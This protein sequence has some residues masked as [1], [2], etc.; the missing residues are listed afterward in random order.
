[1]NF[2]HSLFV[3]TL[4]LSCNAPSSQ[5]GFQS[6]W[7]NMPDQN[8]PGPDFWANRLQ[9]WYVANGRLECKR[10]ETGRPMRTLHWLTG[11]MEY[12]DGEMEMSVLTGKV[13]SAEGGENPQAASG[14]LLGSG[15]SM[16]Y[17]AAAW[18][19]NS[20]GKEG[21]IFAG[22]D[23]QGDL[24][25]KEFED[26]AMRDL[27]R[28]KGNK[29]LNGQVSL[30]VKIIPKGKVCTL[31][32][33]ARDPKTDKSINQI[34]VDT[35]TATR[36]LGN[37]SLVSHPGTGEQGGNSFWF[38]DWLIYGDRIELYPNRSTGPILTAQH[39]LNKGI[40]KM[41]AQLMP[42]SAGDKGI[43]EFQTREGV[44]WKTIAQAPV[45][46]PGY[47]A[48]FRIPSWNDKDSIPYRLQYVS[49]QPVE[50]GAFE[51]IVRADPIKKKTIVLAGLSCNHN[52]DFSGIPNA[53]GIEGSPYNWRDKVWFP[54][55][56][57]IE[58]LKKQDPDILFFAGDQIYESANPSSKDE[59]NIYE[60]YL[61]KWYLWCWAFRDLTKDIPTVCIP[62]DHDIFQGN[63]WGAAGRKT[64]KDDKGGYVHP[65]EFVNM[66]QRTQTG[67]LPDPY[68]ATPVNQSIGVY[69]TDWIYGGISFAILEDRKF[70]EGPNGRTPKTTSG[71]AD[72]VTDPKVN[73]RAY[74]VDLPLLGDRQQAFL[75]KWAQDWDGVWMKAVLSQT[76]F[77]NV[78][79]HHGQDQKRIFM[80]LDSNGWPQ[81]GRNKALDAIRR[82]HAFM[83]AGDQHLASFVQ[84][85]IEDYGDA[86]Y[87]FV[88]PAIA[89]FYLRTWKPEQS[90]SP[91]YTGRFMDGFGNKITVKAVANPGPP[92]GKEP[93][94]LYDKVPGYGIVKFEKKSGNIISECWPRDADPTV[95]K[96]Y[97]G[98]PQKINLTDNYNKQAKLWLPAIHN[99]SPD[100]VMQVI[101]ESNGEVVYTLRI[102]GNTFLPKVYKP[103]NYTLR[104]GEGKNIKVVKNLAA[105]D[106]PFESARGL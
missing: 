2:L 46:T 63:L 48:T 3:V 40:L 29:E 97:P 87:S 39:T 15:R 42:V 65:A 91:D 51:G 12:S 26:A 64:D 74:D 53:P 92:T 94:N 60:D 79:T 85:G 10:R 59:E 101:D 104:V 66:V 4:T 41:T 28:K 103:G 105:S 11:R 45:I 102:R 54:H 5:K 43:V 72:H 69:Y 78:A 96:Q 14:F 34:Q 52:F 1:M 58:S 77:A 81:K 21:G 16:D 75:D 99:P 30:Y 37:I 6:S 90:P 44:E 47:T 57:L 61:Y 38:N 89:N 106:V 31:I 25:I 32:L 67:H 55:L 22:M 80:D 95:D 19:H 76:V 27:A 93:A 62:D 98:W 9:D 24:F 33:E 50:Q 86:G 56:D 36:L 88:V 17:K 8:W 49:D 20:P 70:K 35:L 13:S 84:H 100:A 23:L 82:A 18:I 71:R 68:D 83:I 73:S 7:K